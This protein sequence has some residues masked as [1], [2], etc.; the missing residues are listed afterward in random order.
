MRIATD[1]PV[2]DFHDL[3]LLADGMSK[4]KP[5]PPDRKTK[6]PMSGG[7]RQVSLPSPHCVVEGLV[8]SL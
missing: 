5:A 4:Y 6:F 3:D 7:R 1:Q 2:L 8:A